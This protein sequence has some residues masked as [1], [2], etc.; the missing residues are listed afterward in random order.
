MLP[1]LFLSSGDLI[2]DRRF[3]WARGLHA[4]G[5]LAGA[6]ELLT[7]AVG[8]APQFAAAWFALG[9]I[10]ESLGDRA[11]AIDA[12]RAACSVDPEDRHGA[13]LQLARLGAGDMQPAAPAGYMRAL[14]DQYAPRF[15]ATLTGPLN[16]RAPEL[17]LRAV[18]GVRR[19]RGAQL[20]FGAMLDLGCGTGLAG[21]AFR[22]CVDWLAG[23]DISPGM[24]AQAR[25]KGLYDRLTVGDMGYYLAEAAA[26]GAQHHLV[27]AA[28][29][30]VYVNALDDIVAGAARVLAPAGLLAFTAETHAGRGVILRESL[31]HAHGEDHVRDALAAAGLRPLVLERRSTRTET[32]QPVPGLLVVAAR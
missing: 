22:P 29:V 24:I 23:V 3:E 26:A 8:L 32:A 7:Q 31:R 21:A 27:V 17:L 1:P 11:G 9:E 25:R 10:R 28:D 13:S 20:R 30:L 19:E 6:A 5:D 4:S 15:D 14:F 2:A 12:F 18:E 16:Y